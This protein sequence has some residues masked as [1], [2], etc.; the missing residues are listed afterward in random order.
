M[1]KFKKCEKC[2]KNFECKSLKAKW[3]SYDCGSRY[4]EKLENK[5]CIHCG[6]E[7]VGTKNKKYCSGK[8]V[9]E[10]RTDHLKKIHEAK[11]KYPKIEGLNRCQIFRKF[12]PEKNRIELHKDNLKR[13]ILIQALGGKCIRCDYNED[14]RALQIDHKHGDGKEDRKRVGSKIARYYIKNI[15]EAKEK[16]QI[17]CSNCHSIKTFENNDSIPIKYREKWNKNPFPV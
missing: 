3:C 15:E 13:G 9:A 17:L 5:N 7:F 12:N 10:K 11:R 14:L 2:G 8:C 6:K 4:F 1:K 16:L